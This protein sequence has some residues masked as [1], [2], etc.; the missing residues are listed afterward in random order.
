M[1]FSTIEPDRF[2][3]QPWIMSRG[4]QPPPSGSVAASATRTSRFGRTSSHRGCFRPFAKARTCSPAAGL[5]V[6]L[7]GHG[8]LATDHLIV[9]I[10]VL[11]GSGI[12]GS[13]PKPGVCCAHELVEESRVLQ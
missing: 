10:H 6:A 13:G 1:A 8:S 11:L 7:F 4:D 2:C 12:F 5:G 3:A 9:G